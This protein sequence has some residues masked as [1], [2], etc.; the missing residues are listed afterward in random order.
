MMASLSRPEF[1]ELGL[2]SHPPSQGR[3][4]E[5]G[6][7][8][9][10]L[11]ALAL[12][13]APA[14]ARADADLDPGGM[15]FRDFAVSDNGS[16]FNKV[17]PMIGSGAQPTQSRIL[18]IDNA[19]GFAR[20]RFDSIRT[21][22]AMP[23][24]WQA[25]EDWERGVGFSADKRYRMIVWRVD[26][27][28]E[29]VNDAEHYAATKAGAIQARKPGSRAEVRKLADGSFLIVYQNVPGEGEARAV[30]DLVVP[31]PSKPKEGALM[32]L[33]VPMADIERGLRL[34][35]LLKQKLRIDW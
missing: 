5:S 32:T 13:C 17:D 11:G 6:R 33:G 19:G 31:R 30:F 21:E 23:L 10:L 15:S 1:N 4:K 22:V 2:K 8:P 24:G 34:M 7:R 16:S 9:F 18:A 26:F 3:Q 28:F 25:Q 35:A 29:G 12:A 20:I 27:A 14:A